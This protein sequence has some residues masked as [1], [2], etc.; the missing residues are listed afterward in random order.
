MSGS[1]NGIIE[2]MTD[3]VNASLWTTTKILFHLFFN[4]HMKLLTEVICQF[5]VQYYYG[6]VYV[7]LFI[8]FL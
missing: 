8:R 6:N 1:V 7:N 2:E 4:V 5:R 3:P